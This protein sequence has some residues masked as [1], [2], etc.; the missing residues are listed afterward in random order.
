MEILPVATEL[1]HADGQTERHK[2]A[3]RLFHNFTKAPENFCTTNS[4]VYTR[5]H[6]SQLKCQC[7]VIHILLSYVSHRHYDAI[8]DHKMYWNVVSRIGAVGP[9][10]DLEQYG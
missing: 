9:T 1:L 10:V 4:Y 6:S 5:C 7:T 8:F 2:E 3:N